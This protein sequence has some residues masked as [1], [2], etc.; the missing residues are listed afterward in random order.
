[1]FWEDLY[2]HAT[3]R[4]LKAYFKFWRIYDLLMHIFLIAALILRGIR[5]GSYTIEC[6]D[7]PDDA[8]CELLHN[9]RKIVHD[10]ESVFL[11][12]VA[13][14]SIQRYF[15]DKFFTQGLPK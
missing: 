5:I 1:M 4:S 11:A 15:F 12:I 10:L 14:T 2:V 3:L 6:V 9:N 13:I 7:L 8:T